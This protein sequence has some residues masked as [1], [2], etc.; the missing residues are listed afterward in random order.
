MNGVWARL[1][2]YCD[3]HIQP[4]V[5]NPPLKDATGPLA[6]LLQLA[7]GQALDRSLFER[8]QLMPFEQCV[9]TKEMLDGL[10]RK[11]AWDAA[12][13]STDWHPF[14]ED[15]TGNHLV[16]DAKS[17][18]V[19]EF[20]HDDDARPLWGASME[21]WLTSFVEK[22]ESGQLIY[23]EKVGVVERD[24]REKLA[25]QKAARRAVAAP[26]EAKA[27]RAQGVFFV[28]LAVVLAF[29]VIAA[30]MHRG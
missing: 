16:L 3:A 22:L 8:Y 5:F 13:W 9:S 25:A 19:I 14:A 10:A 30:L 20:L 28:G 2:R 1:V 6:P 29:I 18:E 12:W 7:D 27:Q 15:I 17:G 23:D 11:E 4:G 21:A 26:L 24:F